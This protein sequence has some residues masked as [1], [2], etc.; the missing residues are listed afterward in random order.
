MSDA[1]GRLM[2][3]GDSHGGFRLTNAQIV[4][5]N[6]VV[7]GHLAVEG[8]LIVEVEAGDARGRDMGGG[9]LIPGIVD[10]HTDHVE[11][12]VFPRDGVQWDFLAALLAH[13]AVVVAG[14]VTTVFDSLSVGATMRRPERRE[15]LAPLIDALE[16]GQEAGL[17][18]AEHLLHMRCEICDPETMGL[19]DRNIGRWVARL[20]SV[21]DHTPG[22]RQSVDVADWTRRMARDMQIDPDEA[23]MRL[24]ELLA[25]SARVGPEVR[26]HVI[27]AARAHDLPLMSHDDRTSAHVEQAASEGIGV[28]EFPTTLIAARR[29]KA[30][31]QAVVVGAPNYLRG[32]SQ[33]GN[34]AVRALLRTGVVDAL[35]S[36]YV[37]GSLL[38]AAFAIAADRDLPHDLAAAI[39]MV[40]SAPA[41]LAGLT[42]RGRLAPGQRAD[43]AC[44]RAT[45][46]CRSPSAVWRRGIQVF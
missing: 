45:R 35:A 4:T 40:T 16:F 19:V 23:G 12:H 29:A 26:R 8:G 31:G 15:I 39:R 22:D 24:E 34:V 17:F 43:M 27:A 18:R 5:P 7:H 36:D 10:L 42:D 30:L 1:P 20:V 6:K 38:D 32:G 33:S 44:I 41:A 11:T 21:M 28:A 2:F 46:S 13:D 3:D 37:P 25:R 9:V 14:A